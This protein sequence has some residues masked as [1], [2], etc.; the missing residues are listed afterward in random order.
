MIM[1]IV[2][3]LVILDNLKWEYVK[4]LIGIIGDLCLFFIAVYTFRLTIFPKKLKL[5]GLSYQSGIWDGE[6]IEFILE[7]RSISPVVV[8]AVDLIVDSKLVQVYRGGCIIDGFKTET[9]RLEPYLQ[10]IAEDKVI[11][12]SMNPDVTLYVETSRG[13]YYIKHERE[14]SFLYRLKKQRLDRFTKTTVVRNYC[15][16][17]L[18]PVST[19][20]ILT[21]K[22]KDEG[23]NTIFIDESGLMSDAIF[24]FNSLPK[25]IIERE[26]DL[27][28]VF[29]VEFEKRKI[30]YSLDKHRNICK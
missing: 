24:G 15:N 1:N 22:V 17:K 19:K 3:D 7:N 14:H 9:I 18:I 26:T 28:D 6:A 16:G 13:K 11:D 27:R 4:N 8:R 30:P 20:Y 21:Y 2:S 12:I 23:V 10:I 29:D 5:I 25:E